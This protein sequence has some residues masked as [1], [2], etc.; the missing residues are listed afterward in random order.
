ML[1]SSSYALPDARIAVLLNANAGQVSPSLAAE[2]ATIVPKDRVFLTQSALHSRD[3][4]R[5]CVADE[6]STV[7]AGGGDGTIVGVI[8]DLNECHQQQAPHLPNV[9]VL[10]LG[11]GNALARWLG[12][13]RPAEDLRRWQGG[14]IH[15]I[16]PLDMVSSEETIFPFAGMGHDA[17]L[18]NDYNRLKSIAHKKWW[19]PLASGMSGYV[20]TGALTTLPRLLRAP[21]TRI[22]VI[23]TGSPA[24]RCGSD[25][26]E[27]GEPIPTGGLLYEGPS[28]FIGTATTPLYGYGMR[29]FPHA[30]RRAGRFQLR[31][32]DLTP[33]EIAANLPATWR[34]TIRHPKVHD[35]YA[36]RIRVRAEDAMPYQL[37]GEACGYRQ[38]MT[39]TTTRAPIKLIAQ[40]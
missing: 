26:R 38:E 4:L 10:R 16:V 32:A 20:L 9:G 1:P 29:M 5:R 35:F 39:F 23:N 40:G 31:I 11:T 6:I 33:I 30:T 36:D 19:A 22:Q 25:G 15:R 8:N 24:Y 12:S 37:A 21:P 27:I 7:F 3:I 34:G 17:A 2:L 28:T 13:G 18:L 14:Q